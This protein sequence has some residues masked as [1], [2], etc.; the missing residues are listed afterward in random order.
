MVVHDAFDEPVSRVVFGRPDV[1]AEVLAVTL[2]HALVAVLFSVSARD[3]L[4]IVVTEALAGS[5]LRSA[6][7][8]TSAV[9]L[10][11]VIEDSRLAT[12]WSKFTGAHAHVGISDSL[13]LSAASLAFASGDAGVLVFFTISALD[14]CVNEGAGAV[15]RGLLDFAE[16]SDQLL[17]GDT[18]AVAK[19]VIHHTLF[20]AATTVIELPDFLT[21]FKVC[22]RKHSANV[23]RLAF[24]L[25]VS[26][27]FGRFAIGSRLLPVVHVGILEGSDKRCE[28]SE[29][30]GS[31]SVSITVILAI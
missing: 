19:R 20:F 30:Q 13:H 17:R 18:A 27:E 14:R 24:L 22:V 29:R 4:V 21:V 8:F 5:D 25:A 12:N 28:H 9:S 3:W 1:L 7:L 10:T 15:V 2:G 23:V 6:P 16:A 26:A 31:H 11:L